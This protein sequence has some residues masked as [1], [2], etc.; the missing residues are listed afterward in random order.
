MTTYDITETLPFSLSGAAAAVEAVYNEQQVLPDVT[1]GGM[2]FRFALGEGSA[3]TRGT[4]DF[5]RQQIDTSKEPGEQ[6]LAAWWTRHQTSWH[7]GAGITFYEPGSDE[8]TVFRYQSSAGID[9]WTNGEI[10]LLK[11]MESLISATAGQEC[12]VTSA[13]VSGTDVIFT[14]VGGTVSRHDGTTKTDYSATPTPASPVVVAGDTILV[15]S[16]DGILSGSS[17]GSSLSTLWTTSTTLLRP[18]WVKSRIIAAQGADLHDLTLTGGALGT[19]HWSHPDSGW[20]WTA[21]AEGPDA[22]LASGRSNGYSAIYALGLSDN[23]TSKTPDLGAVIQVAELPPGEEIYA[24]VTYLGAYIAVGT[25]RGIRIGTLAAEGAIQLGPLTVET[26]HP[27]RSITARGSYFFAGVQEDI[28]GNS[29]AV[30]IDISTGIPRPTDADVSLTYVPTLRYAYAYDGDTGAT[31]IC[32]GVA[33]LGT[34]ERLALGVQGSGVYLQSD[35]DYVDSGYLLSGRTRFSTAEPKTFRYVKIRTTIGDDSTVG[36]SSIDAGGSELNVFTFGGAFDTSE[37]IS[38]GSLAGTPQRHMAVKLTLT[39]S[40][41]SETSPVVEEIQIKALPLPRLQREIQ[42][43]LRLHDIEEDRNGQRVGYAGSAVTRL[44]V[45][46]AI[47]EENA[48]VTVTDH[49]A[50]ESFSAMIK[51]VRFARTAPPARN[52]H[53][54]GGQLLVSLVKL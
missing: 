21:V 12:Y 52:R 20:E 10:K 44:Q 18:W 34:S 43:P 14:E 30:R 11:K 1:I 9:P 31:G 54:F 49:T 36:I 8:S 41:D 22:I 2:P 48:V 27:V 46:E 51:D 38:L 23:G 45:L 15:G 26:T 53:N 25:N 4:L 35:T 47:Q 33:F 42:I 24:M 5:K 7:R 32:H 28:D 39:A 17:S 6:T 50:G 40:T 19:A 13:V 3:Y 16:T 37:D 29:G